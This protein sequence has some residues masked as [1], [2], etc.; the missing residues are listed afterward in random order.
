MKAPKKI[1]K[2]RPKAKR[3]VNDLTEK[4]KG[5]GRNEMTPDQMMF[6]RS[7]KGMNRGT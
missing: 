2:P 3:G 6:R 7:R 1:M 4:P 5:K